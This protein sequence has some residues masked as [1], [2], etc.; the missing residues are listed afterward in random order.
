[1]S[2]LFPRA[3]PGE[4][5]YQLFAAWKQAAQVTISAR[6]WGLRQWF[7]ASAGQLAVQ[8]YEVALRRTLLD[9]GYLFLRSLP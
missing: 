4:P 9:K 1:M 7:I 5:I 8:G 2:A 3:V 6:T